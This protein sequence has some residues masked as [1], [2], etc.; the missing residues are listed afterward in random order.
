MEEEDEQ[1]LRNG[2]TLQTASKSADLMKSLFL[3]GFVVK[4][5]GDSKS[6][7]YY[8]MGL[9]LGCGTHLW[10]NKIAGFCS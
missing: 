6:Q 1:F 7:F 8:N 5:T 4:Q 9:F 10:L 2:S 3:K